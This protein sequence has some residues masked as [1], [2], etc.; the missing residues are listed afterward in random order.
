[1]PVTIPA[2]QSL[3]TVACA[4]LNSATVPTEFELGTEGA[5]NPKY[6]ISVHARFGGAN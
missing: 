3:R 5:Q 2:M 4:S 6:L 1:M